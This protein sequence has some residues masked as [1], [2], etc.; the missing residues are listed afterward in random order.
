MTATTTDF[1][2]LLYYNPV[3]KGFNPVASATLRLTNSAPINE[4]DQIDFEIV[5]WNIP[6]G[7]T[8][9]WRLAN[10]TNIDS[11]RFIDVSD[12]VVITRNRGYFSTA[13]N[14][15][16]T[17]ATGPQTFDVVIDKTP[18]GGIPSGQLA[19]LPSVTVVDSSV[20]IPDPLI[21]NLDGTNPGGIG[22]SMST[23]GTGQDGNGYY[24][25]I[26]G[27]YG[28]YL[29]VLQ[30]VDT[31]WTIS[32][33]ANNLVNV[34]VT[35]VVRSNFN[36]FGALVGAVYIAVDP[37]NN[38]QPFTFT[39]SVLTWNDQTTHSNNGTLVNGP[40]YNTAFGGYFAFDG[41][42]DYIA[43]PSNF[44]DWTN[45]PFTIS[46]WYR[47]SSA[48]IVLGQT[49]SVTPGAATGWVPAVYITTGGV[50]NISTFY[51]GSSNTSGISGLADGQWHNMTITYDNGTQTTY[52]DGITRL[53]VPGLTQNGYTANYYY[54]LGAGKN[55]GW[56]FAGSE[57]FTGDIAS[58]KV[59]TS[60]KSAG[61]V[62]AEFDNTKSRFLP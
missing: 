55:T 33:G 54:Y 51:H 21:M 31:T 20:P 44:I 40:T 23:P 35:S 53:Q 8:L 45:T 10:I 12:S 5:T 24:I 50:T 2:G 18:G 60:A 62:T 16:V 56:P 13:V 59:W 19:V 37:G 4:G 36:N 43:L 52:I 39:P 42:N 7:T 49:D 1:S 17:T 27:N 26:N 41:S 61:E 25:M 58:F 28:P 9:Y 3:A 14:A 57:Y 11:G 46:I 48:G 6:D 34:P 29:T 30:S 47:T 38:S 22:T 32:G 15:D